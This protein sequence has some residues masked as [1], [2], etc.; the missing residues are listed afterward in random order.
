MERAAK[1]KQV[2]VA[3]SNSSEFKPIFEAKQF[4]ESS[5]SDRSGFGSI[6]QSKQNLSEF[7]LVLKF[8]FSLFCIMPIP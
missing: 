5:G 8:V 6:E 2:K 7:F 1:L 3:E 4:A